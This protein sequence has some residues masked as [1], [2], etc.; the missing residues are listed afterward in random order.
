LQ[1]RSVC[2]I[3][4]EADEPVAVIRQFVRILRQCAV[5]ATDA[6]IAIR[7]I[8]VSARAA[9]A[10]REFSPRRTDGASFAEALAIVEELA[11]LAPA[12]LKSLSL[13]L[14]AEDFHWK[15]ASAATRGKLQLL[16]L[17]SFRQKQRFG[18][19]SILDLHAADPRSDEV[20]ALLA[21]V[22]GQSGLGFSIESSAVVFEATDRQRA[23]AEQLLVTQLA[24]NELTHAVAERLRPIVDIISLPQLMSSSASIS[25][26]FDPSKMGKSVRVDFRKIVQRWF[27]EHFAD[28]EPRKVREDDHGIR[29]TI[30]PHLNLFFYFDK[31]PRA[32]SKTFTARF[33]MEFTAPQYA[34]TPD[35][36]YRLQADFLEL[37]ELFMYGWSYFTKE[38]L[39][40]ALDGS[41]ATIRS[42]L[43]LME[44]GGPRYLGEALE[45]KLDEF[46]GPREITAREACDLALP[47]VREWAYD[48]TLNS[49]QLF[50]ILTNTEFVT[51]GLPSHS[52]EGR[53][54][55]AGQW[56]MIFHSA[57]RRE[58]M[59]LLVPFRGVIRRSRFP[60]SRGEEMFSSPELGR[61]QGLFAFVDGWIDS[62]QALERALS[63]V[64]PEGLTEAELGAF[65]MRYDWKNGPT[66]R[67]SLQK[68]KKKDHPF[69]TVQVLVPAYGKGEAQAS[70]TQFDQ[71]GVPHRR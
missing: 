59:Q 23:T 60:F 22:K 68:K 13:H 65:E 9:T 69:K 18:L 33:G 48:A 16:D 26:R 14:S 34:V 36:P 47:L 64:A 21:A 44:Q 20:V 17:K 5:P 32:F 3:P 27:K 46:D 10:I 31:H 40:K 30:A 56:R 58:K 62:G 43:T 53:L 1:I 54:G 52:G 12:K 70:V 39:L 24:W 38:D 4:I 71:D 2:D 11:A 15:G 49:I 51:A 28:Y 55:P 19:T 66:W 67:F 37:F 42:V 35:R 57:A 61:L 41:L 25:Y 63:R 50:L 45:R 7:L 6:R 29:K 8:G